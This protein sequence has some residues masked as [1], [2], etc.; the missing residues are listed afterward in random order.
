MSVY[1]VYKVQLSFRT[2]SKL[3]VDRLALLRSGQGA[4]TDPPDLTGPR[5]RTGHTAGQALQTIMAS[6]FAADFGARFVISEE[7]GKDFIQSGSLE[8]GRPTGRAARWWETGRDQCGVVVGK[9]WRTREDVWC[10][11]VCERFVVQSWWSGSS[12]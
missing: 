6:W 12:I 1:I 4:W 11:I 5:T 3:A 10:S 9:P 8:T 7:G 2:P